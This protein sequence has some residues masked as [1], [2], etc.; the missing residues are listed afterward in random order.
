MKD[1][2]GSLQCADQLRDV[3]LL[4]L[5]KVK[6]PVLLVFCFFLNQLSEI[7]VVAE[8]L[9]RPKIRFARLMMSFI[10]LGEIVLNEF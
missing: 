4:K 3:S 8:A 5:A 2:G 9:R 6:Q 10:L 1:G 7:G